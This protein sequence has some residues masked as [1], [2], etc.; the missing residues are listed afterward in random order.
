M[1]K[2]DPPQKAVSKEFLPHAKATI[3]LEISV[4]PLSV[5]RARTSGLGD[6]HP[7]ERKRSACFGFGGSDLFLTQLHFL[8]CRFVVI[9][10]NFG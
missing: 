10:G 7:Q 6:L 5:H 2:F 1:V 9:D 4:T 8:A 3:C